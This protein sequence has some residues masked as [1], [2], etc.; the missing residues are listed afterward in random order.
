MA[1]FG[2]S[3]LHLSF[4]SDKPM[5]IFHGWDNHTEKLKANWCRIVKNED[6]VVLP[7]DF[8]W[9][10]K[11]EDTLEDFRFLSSLPGKKVILKGNHDLWW[12]TS[13]KIHN[14]FA[15]NNIN[16]VEIVFNNCYP[17][18]GGFA[19][20]GTRG[21]AVDAEK[22]STIIKREAARLKTSLEAA[23]EKGLKPVVFTHYPVVSKEGVCA[24]IYNVLC[25]YEINTVY[26]G[27][28]HG[29]SYASHIKE[30]EHITQKL[31]SCDCIDFTPF[32]ILEIK[33]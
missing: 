14:F 16:D 33:V 8:S 25:E 2:I 7:G 13:A 27:H 32:E 19:V 3:D 28:I 9:A 4:G 5:D 24:D 6:V 11:L 12:S 23:K 29:G 15:E 26:H 18:P 1:V 17:L 31:L 20:C 30:F 21:W 22:A 10:L